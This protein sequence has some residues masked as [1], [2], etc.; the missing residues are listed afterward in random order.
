MLRYCYQ[1]IHTTLLSTLVLAL[2]QSPA[3]LARTLAYNF[4]MFCSL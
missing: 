4:S 1:N 2:K 3:L